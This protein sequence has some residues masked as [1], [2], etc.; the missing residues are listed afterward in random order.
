MQHLEHKPRIEVLKVVAVTTPFFREGS[1]QLG[2]GSIV[3]CT[4]VPSEKC[5]NPTPVVG[6]KIGY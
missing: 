4:T 5:R 1:P 6:N 2:D 3:T